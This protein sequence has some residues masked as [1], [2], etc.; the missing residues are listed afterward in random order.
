MQ[1]VRW[2]CSIAVTRVVLNQQGYSMA[3]GLR[4]VSVCGQVNHL[5]RKPAG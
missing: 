3:A 5:G 1:I 4:W 2:W